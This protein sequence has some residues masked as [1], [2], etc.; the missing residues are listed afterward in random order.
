MRWL[1]LDL[2]SKRIGVAASD[3]LGKLAFALKVISSRSLREDVEG[4]AALAREGGAEGI[5][6][7]L[8]LR[9]TGDE[10]PQARRARNFAG[11]LEKATGLAV[12][13]W[14]ERLSTVAAER[15]RREARVRSAEID[16]QAAA[17]ILQNYLDSL[18]S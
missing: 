7:G 6:V 5:V 15:S 4:I 16:A 9:L 10:G 3:P 11:E 17:I 2:G 13:L 1:G 18:G 12:V 14:D 8:P